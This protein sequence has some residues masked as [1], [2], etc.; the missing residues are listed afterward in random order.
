MRGFIKTLPMKLKRDSA[1]AP[2]APPCPV[3]RLTQKNF[4][5]NNKHSNVTLYAPN[6]PFPALAPTTDSVRTKIT[7]GEI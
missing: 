7:K 6:A 5:L 4:T 1:R 2:T 3:G